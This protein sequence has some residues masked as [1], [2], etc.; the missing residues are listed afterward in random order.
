MKMDENENG[1]PLE[2]NN[3]EKRFKNLLFSIENK[4]RL[5][6]NI[7]DISVE[8]KSKRWGFESHSSTHRIY[9]ISKGY[10]M[11]ISDSNSK[12]AF[13]LFMGDLSDFYSFYTKLI[14]MI[15]SID[16]SKI[17]SVKKQLSFYES[18]ENVSSGNSDST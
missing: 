11:N 4:Y 7:F 16:K 12:E 6:L 1:L 14:E 10:K 2:I 3:L 18:K 15:N 13:E 5:A 9:F 17:S 8:S